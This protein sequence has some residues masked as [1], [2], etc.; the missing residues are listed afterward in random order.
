MQWYE[1]IVGID[2]C[3]SYDNWKHVSDDMDLTT[4]LPASVEGL[5]AAHEL[6]SLYEITWPQYRFGVCLVRH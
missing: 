1:I 3:W 4:I 5:A 6:A 2:G